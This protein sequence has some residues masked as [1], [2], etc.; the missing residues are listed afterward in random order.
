MSEVDARRLLP[1]LRE[2]TLTVTEAAK[3][4]DVQPAMVRRWIAE[5]KIAATKSGRSHRIEVSEVDRAKAS[6]S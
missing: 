2:P 1:A 3:R 5:G 6:S 4:L